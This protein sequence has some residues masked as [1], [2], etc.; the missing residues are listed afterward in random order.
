MIWW[1]ICVLNSYGDSIFNLISDAFKQFCLP[2][3]LG[4]FLFCRSFSCPSSFFLTKFSLFCRFSQRPSYFSWFYFCLF[5]RICVSILM[6]PVISTFFSFL[7]VTLVLQSMSYLSYNFF[8]L[9]LFKNVFFFLSVFVFVV[10]GI[11]VA[12][13]LFCR[14]ILFTSQAYCYCVV[15]ARLF[16]FIRIRCFVVS[17]LFF[18]ISHFHCWFCHNFFFFRSLCAFSLSLSL[19]AIDAIANFMFVLHFCENETFWECSAQIFHIQFS[20]LCD[21][22][23][24]NEETKQKSL[25]CHDILYSSYSLFWFSCSMRVSLFFIVWI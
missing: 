2:V 4:Y 16:N 22:T 17:M 23:Q 15:Y 6:F 1:W 19:N 12:D 25:Q 3:F 14:E 7:H 13:F 20:F 11:A 21:S 24:Q 10:V 8:S 5:S 18:D 9:S